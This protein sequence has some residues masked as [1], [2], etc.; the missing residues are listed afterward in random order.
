MG[1][2]HVVADA[3]VDEVS[4][5]LHDAAVGIPV[6]QCRGRDGTLDDVDDDATAEQ[7]DGTTLDKPAERRSE[8]ERETREDRHVRERERERERIFFIT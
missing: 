1:R 5:K 6:V 4:D 8:R 2:T 7:G 3:R